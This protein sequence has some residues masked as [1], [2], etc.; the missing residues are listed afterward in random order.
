MKLGSVAAFLLMF[1]LLVSPALAQAQLGV[2]LWTYRNPSEKYIKDVDITTDGR[3]AAGTAEGLVILFDTKGGKLREINLAGIVGKSFGIEFV[4]ITGDGTYIAAGTNDRVLY[5]INGNTGELLWRQLISTEDPIKDLTIAKN[6]NYVVVSTWNTI[7]IYDV[8]TGKQVASSKI[9]FKVSGLDIVPNGKLIAVG[10]QDSGIMLFD[11]FLNPKWVRLDGTSGFRV[12]GFSGQ[13]VAPFFKAA[14]SSDGNTLV[15]S[16]EF[17]NYYFVKNNRPLDRPDQITRL[18]TDLWT[19]SRAYDISALDL[20]YSGAYAV[21][22]G[23]AGDEKNP[24]LKA[25]AGG[26]IY[27]L[28]EYKV[29]WKSTIDKWWINGAAISQNGKYLVAS[30][31]PTIYFYENPGITLDGPAAPA[32]PPPTTSTPA[33]PPTPQVTTPAPTPA[34]PT[35]APPAATLTPVETPA[36]GKGICGPSLIVALAALAALARRKN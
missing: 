35:T 20:S 28:K 19:G 4:A 30:A 3:V 12:P 33:T 14:I 13:S 8:A 10:T 23:N 7:T 31:G 24:D 21:V 16:T 2:P 6:G 18:T 22:G 25:L 1:A 17:G 32:T 15:G 27:F 5:M 29:L 36:P 34:A 26:M 9:L 11:E